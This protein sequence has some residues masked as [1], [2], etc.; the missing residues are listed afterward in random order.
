MESD[1]WFAPERLE[2]MIS[3]AEEFDSDMVADNI[4]MVDANN[5]FYDPGKVSTS[6]YTSDLSGVKTLFFK[7]L[8]RSLPR[9]VTAAEFIRE[10]ALTSNPQHLGFIK[11]II[12]R[13]FIL[14]YEL[15]YNENKKFSQDF[16]FYF[17]C[18]AQGARLL[19]LPKPYYFYRVLRPGS[20]CSKGKADPLTAT[21][22]RYHTNT[23]LLTRDYGPST[24]EIRQALSFRQH[25]IE[26]YMAYLRLKHAVKARSIAGVWQ[27]RMHLLALIPYLPSRIRL[28]YRDLRKHI[29]RSATRFIQYTQQLLR[30]MAR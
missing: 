30:S 27:E 14:R 12:R 11:P 17:A 15:S 26:N 8:R 7:K 29:M 21:R 9:Y 19:L 2:R 4:F 16:D 20:L 25:T 23:E 5:I 24:A 28:M 6:L 18:L 22:E 1:D 10:N 13:E 3:A